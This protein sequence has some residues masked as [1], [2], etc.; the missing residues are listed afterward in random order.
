MVT[1][2]LS[3]CILCSSNYILADPSN[4]V[5]RRSFQLTKRL[6]RIHFVRSGEF[7]MQA[8]LADV[9]EFLSRWDLRPADLLN[10]LRPLQPSETVLLVGSI[11][12]GLA[13][14]LSDIDLL[15]IGDGELDHEF[16]QRE[17]TSDESVVRLPGGQEINF[18]YWPTSNIEQLRQRMIPNF[19]L[20]NNPMPQGSFTRLTDTELRLLHRLRTGVVLTNPEIATYWRE[21]MQLELLPIYLVLQGVA[22]HFAYREDAIAQIQYERNALSAL[23]M[24]RLAAEYISFSMVAS[25]GE[26]L[27]ARKWLPRLLQRNQEA[28]GKHRVDELMNYYFPNRQEDAETLIGK[29]VDFFDTIIGENLE[30]CPDALPIMLGLSGTISFITNL[31]GAPK[32]AAPGATG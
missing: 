24:L 8:S 22:M 5:R 9:T 13:N 29:A 26:T 10:Q 4:N 32:A 7:L 11:S 18:E 25:V 15:L 19:E 17:V 30:R 21:Q 12:D 27:F 31:D 6:E 3:L 28:L 14:E 20:M 23:A 16:I 1:L 2:T